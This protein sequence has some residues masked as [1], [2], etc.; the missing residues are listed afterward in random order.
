MADS[1]AAPGERRRWMS[2]SAADRR[3]YM[4]TGLDC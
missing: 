3:G 4:L 2:G 1:G